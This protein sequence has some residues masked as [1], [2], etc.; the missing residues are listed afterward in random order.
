[1]YEGVPINKDT[2]FFTYG[3]YFIDDINKSSKASKTNYRGHLNRLEHFGF[4]QVSISEV[5]AS[6]GDDALE[7]VAEF[8]SGAEYAKPEVPAK[9]VTLRRKVAKPAIPAVPRK[10][11]TKASCAT[12]DGYIKTL[13]MIVRQ[14]VKDKLLDENVFRALEIP[15]TALD[16]GEKEVIPPHIWEV[17][18]ESAKSNH[19]LYTY[20]L[21]MKSLG[22]RPSEARALS[23]KNI[24]L[25]TGVIHVK[26]T[27]EAG[28]EG[29]KGLAVTKENRL[30]RKRGKKLLLRKGLLLPDALAVLREYK[31]KQ[32]AELGECEFVFTVNGDIIKKKYFSIPISDLQDQLISEG[33]MNEDERFIAYN[34]R[35]TVITDWLILGMNP[36]EVSKMVGTS[37]KMIEEHYDHSDCDNAIEKL[38]KLSAK[39]DV[40]TA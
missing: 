28:E 31:R 32:T 2:D 12:V 6:H 36:L 22:T 39:P 34:I 16:E 19:M 14:A 5:Q 23:W 21:I 1:M 20:I 26:Q 15:D 13:G 40:L 30:K 11:G 37:L 24:N 8:G 17:F 38:V 35:H 9:P 27:V 10:N 4:L 7:W 29:V 3:R 25:S 18:L 33:K